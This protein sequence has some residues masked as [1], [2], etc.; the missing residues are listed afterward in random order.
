MPTIHCDREDCLYC[1]EGECQRTSI[2]MESD[3]SFSGTYCA[4]VEIKKSLPSANE[5]EQK[6]L[7]NF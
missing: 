3:A 6:Q 5:Q 4:S 2:L 7:S 1:C